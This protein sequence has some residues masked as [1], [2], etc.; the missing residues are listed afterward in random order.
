M[1]FVTWD[2]PITQQLAT[3]WNYGVCRHAISVWT[4]DN[5][6]S[7]KDAVASVR[8]S[9]DGVGWSGVFVEVSLPLNEFPQP[10]LALAVRLCL[11]IREM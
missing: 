1:K 10:H 4:G 9:V 5:S 11:A 8:V 7:F 2:H 6:I 3:Q